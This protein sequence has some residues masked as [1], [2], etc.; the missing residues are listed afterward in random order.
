M[1]E[2]GLALR[3][4]FLQEPCE[5]KSS[6]RLQLITRKE[7]CQDLLLVVW[8]GDVL[9]IIL[10]A[11]H[12]SPELLDAFTETL[13]ELGQLLGPEEDEND[14]E[15]DKQFAPADILKHGT[16]LL[17]LFLILFGIR[18][19]VRLILHGILKFLDSGTKPFGQFRDLLRAEKYQHDKKY[20]DYFCCSKIPHVLSPYAGKR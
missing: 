16:L 2:Q 10:K 20:Q 13:T 1:R 19:C 14:E 17:L 3:G 18:R 11:L 8:L 5:A 12:R 9:D 4:A 7:L 6:L 15:N